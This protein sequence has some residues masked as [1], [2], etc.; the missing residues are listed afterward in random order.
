[1]S[2]SNSAGNL[3]ATSAAPDNPARAP[4]VPVVL[5][6]SPE[7][8]QYFNELNSKSIPKFS[9][10]Q[11]DVAEAFFKRVEARWANYVALKRYWPEKIRDQLM[12]GKAEEFARCFDT[13]D[14]D[15]FKKR[16]CSKYDSDMARAHLRLAM[17]DPVYLSDVELRKAVMLATEDYNKVGEDFDGIECALRLVSRVPQSTLISYRFAPYR[18]KSGRAILKKLEELLIDVR[19]SS[20]DLPKWMLPR[21]QDTKDAAEETAVNKTHF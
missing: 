16:I 13:V 19:E 1:M 9:G 7:L 8:L 12:E 14:Y 15:E 17:T 10:H 2:A 3:D 11:Q 21:K 5:P 4:A 6:A 20:P 18:M